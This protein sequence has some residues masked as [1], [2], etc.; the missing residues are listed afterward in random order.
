MT[1]EL[2]IALI[3]AI[4]QLVDQLRN[5]TQEVHELKMEIY[6]HD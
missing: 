3:G 5:L 2:T 6:N 4:N 1:E